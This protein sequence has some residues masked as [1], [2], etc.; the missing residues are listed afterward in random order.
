MWSG[1]VVKLSGDTEE[2]EKEGGERGAPSP[3]GGGGGR[4]GGGGGA[5]Y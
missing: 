1:G 5:S 2:W 3:E 4:R